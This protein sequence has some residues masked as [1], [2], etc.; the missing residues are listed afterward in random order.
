M[1]QEWLPTLDNPTLP[2]TK[3]A[4]KTHSTVEC[5]R[6]VER[7]VCDAHSFQPKPSLQLRPHCS[8]V[9]YLR[10]VQPFLP[11]STTAR[12]CTGP[13][14]LPRPA[15]HTCMLRTLSR[16]PHR[17]P[18]TRAQQ[19]NDR[20]GAALA[21]ATVRKKIASP[22]SVRGPCPQL[23]A[24]PT[25]AMGRRG[26][27]SPHYLWVTRTLALARCTRACVL[28]I[29]ICLDLSLYLSLYLSPYHSADS[30]I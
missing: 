30:S 13:A 16:G 21:Y 25:L 12:L 18:C 27:T 17:R 11:L 19:W 1:G 4:K 22:P 28:H 9:R 10:P 3:C 6:C 8:N 29:A 7:C 26:P 2:C 5:H 24:V 14:S 15:F 23:P 20:R